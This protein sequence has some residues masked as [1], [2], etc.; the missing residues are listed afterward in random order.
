[1]SSGHLLRVALRQRIWNI[2]LIGAILMRL[3]TETLNVFW[4]DHFSCTE[5]ILSYITQRKPR[6]ELPLFLI[7]GSGSGVKTF[8]SPRWKRLSLD[9]SERWPHRWGPWD[10]VT[11]DP[12]LVRRQTSP[13]PRPERRQSG[14]CLSPKE[15]GGRRTLPSL[16][17][18]GLPPRG[19]HVRAEKGPG[20]ENQL[21]NSILLIG[22]SDGRAHLH[23]VG[24][25]TFARRDGMLG[26]R[27]RARRRVRQAELGERKLKAKYRSQR[28]WSTPI[29]PLPSLPQVDPPTSHQTREAL[30]TR[31]LR[32]IICC[33]FRT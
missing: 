1:M 12:G 28:S 5:M 6:F 13:F 16:T 20:R 3:H 4:R 25:H 32:L 8:V 10:A 14:L 31:A 24:A 9:C 19:R 11:W 33:S 23:A 7:I 22:Q 27:E 15:G 21:R 2:T 17:R 29:I 26:K 18:P 30:Q